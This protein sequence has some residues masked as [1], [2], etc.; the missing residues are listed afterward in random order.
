MF[1]NYYVIGCVLDFCAEEML[2]QNEV[3]ALNL[4][5]LQKMIVAVIN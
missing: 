5:L 2:T 1:W 3:T 4:N